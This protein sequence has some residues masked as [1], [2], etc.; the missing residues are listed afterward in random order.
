MVVVSDGGGMVRLRL[1]ER[2]NTETDSFTQ[3]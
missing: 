1:W 2:I 3:G